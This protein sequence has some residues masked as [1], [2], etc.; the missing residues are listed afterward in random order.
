MTIYN[1]LQAIV[2]ETQ[3]RDITTLENY[4][5]SP[6]GISTIK[7]FFEFYARKGLTDTRIHIEKEGNPR[8]RASG[9]ATLSGQL[10]INNAEPIRGLVD[11]NGVGWFYFNMPN[12]SI[13]QFRQEVDDFVAYLQSEGLT[14]INNKGSTMADLLISW[15]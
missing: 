15:A 8:N 14:V 7:G 4:I 6:I 2:D 9:F 3:Q 1:D 5:L 11:R 10:S 13:E 12:A